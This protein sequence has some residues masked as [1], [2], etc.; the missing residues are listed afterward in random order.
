MHFTCCNCGKT[1]SVEPVLIN[2]GTYCRDCEMSR[3]KPKPFD[4]TK[5]FR[6]RVGD[7]AAEIFATKDGKHWGRRQNLYCGWVPASWNLDGTAYRDS[8]DCDLVNVPE[9]RR[10]KVWLHEYS[11]GENTVSLVHPSHDSYSVARS[12]LEAC[13]E[14]EIE[15]EV[16]E[17]MSLLPE[18]E[19]KI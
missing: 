15:Y 8:S 12:F 17:G 14:R 7:G 2:G 16:G 6:L 19:G 3:A 13:V 18:Q 5:P 1:S 9:K 11:N 10:V 4:P